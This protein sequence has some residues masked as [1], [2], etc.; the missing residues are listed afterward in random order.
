MAITG[1]M[2][3]QLTTQIAR[4][5]LTSASPRENTRSEAAVPRIAANATYVVET[6]S[7]RPDANAITLAL[8][9]VMTEARKES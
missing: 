8:T 6:G 7:P 5:T 9:P 3:Q 2:N 4:P 1:A